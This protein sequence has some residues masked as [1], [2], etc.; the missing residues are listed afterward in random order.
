MRAMSSGILEWATSRHPSACNLKFHLPYI[1]Y[2]ISTVLEFQSKVLA[3]TLGPA[4]WNYILLTSHITYPQN[5][6]H[7]PSCSFQNCLAFKLNLK[8]GTGTRPSLKASRR[9]SS[10]VRPTPFGQAVEQ[11][12]DELLY[13][14]AECD[15]YSQWAIHRPPEI[16]LERA[17][18]TWRSEPSWRLWTSEEPEGNR[19]HTWVKFVIVFDSDT[20]LCSTNLPR[21]NWANQENQ[22]MGLALSI[23]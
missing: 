17:S 1:P 4:I 8:N 6:I 19:D 7:F 13:F 18:P 16:A 2:S 23:S 9:V 5:S 21:C 10:M 14:Q 11:I 3:D 12:H 20:F 15:S 22:K